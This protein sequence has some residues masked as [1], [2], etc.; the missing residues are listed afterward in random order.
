MREIFEQTESRRSSRE[1]N[2]NIIRNSTNY[3]ISTSYE[4]AESEIW[5]H[6]EEDIPQELPPIESLSPQDT[7]ERYKKRKNIFFTK[8]KKTKKG[9]FCRKHFF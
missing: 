7:K 9:N 1:E 8:N 2:N 6:P 3:L 4:S 5:S